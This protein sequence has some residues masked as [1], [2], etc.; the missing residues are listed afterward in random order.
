MTSLPGVHGEV[1]FVIGVGKSDWFRTPLPPNRTCRSPAF[2]SPVDRS[3]SSGLTDR[4]MGRVAQVDW[5]G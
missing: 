5:V 4:R 3:P 1:E 2:G